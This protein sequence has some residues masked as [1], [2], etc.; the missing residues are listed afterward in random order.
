MKERYISS[1]FY[2]DEPLS[3]DGIN[4]FIPTLE[5]E[6]IPKGIGIEISYSQE[7]YQG[8]IKYF[9][10]S[11]AYDL[12]NKK[13]WGR[14][15]KK[16]YSSVSK[17]IEVENLIRNLREIPEI[18]HDKI[19]MSLIDEINFSHPSD[20]NEDLIYSSLNFLSKY[21][22]IKR[23]GGDKK[24]SINIETGSISMDIVKSSGLTCRMLNLT[25]CANGNVNFYSYD[26]DDADEGHSISGYMTHSGKYKSARKI[27]SIL[28]ILKSDYQG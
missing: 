8:A 3:Y 15:Y 13:M 4:D 9:L 19:I 2:F 23:S 10:T 27:Q 21:H 5:G 6:L 26:N 22:E 17:K 28:N 11:T 18:E 7:E 16:L 20:K 1:D 12:E 25:F 14:I 24:V